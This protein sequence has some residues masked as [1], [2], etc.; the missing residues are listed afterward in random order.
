VQT[1]Q[2]FAQA[3]FRHGGCLMRVTALER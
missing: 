1:L 2:I 3:L